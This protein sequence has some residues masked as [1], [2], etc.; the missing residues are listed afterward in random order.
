M[1][2]GVRR[3]GE[4][5]KSESSTAHCTAWLGRVKCSGAGCIVVTTVLNIRDP[6]TLALLVWNAGH[7]LARIAR[8]DHDSHR[9]AS[10][11]GL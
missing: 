10:T 11:Q 7:L 5:I 9:H 3:Q 6:S 2:G 4:E 8:Q 1:D